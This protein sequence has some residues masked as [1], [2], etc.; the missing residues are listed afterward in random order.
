MSQLLMKNFDEFFMPTIYE[1]VSQRLEVFNEASLGAITLTT[2]GIIGSFKHTSFYASLEAAARDVDQFKATNPEVNPVD[3]AQKEHVEVKFKDAIGPVRYEPG[4]MTWLQKPTG[5]G[6]AVYSRMYA[7]IM[8]KRMINKTIGAAVAAISNNPDATLDVSTENGVNYIGLNDSHAL[9]GDHSSDLV[10]QVMD[11][12]TVH[13][14]IG[15]NLSNANSL[16]DY[17]GVRVI[18]ILGKRTVVT[19]APALRSPADGEEPAKNRVLSLATDGVRVHAQGDMHTRALDVLGRERMEMLIQSEYTTSLSIKGY[20]WDV[21]NGGKSPLSP[22]L[23]TGANWDT[24][25][26]SV[27]HTAGVILIGDAAKN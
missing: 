22:A 24:V 6:I 10:V 12:K 27:K 15:Q 16:Y 8:L 4:Q 1:M 2:E 25:D 9:F 20:S 19:D 14:L 11:G 26:A 3:L 13:Q 21:A 18:D 17:N 7:D 23:F 5:E